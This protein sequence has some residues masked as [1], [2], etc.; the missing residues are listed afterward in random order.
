[1]LLFNEFLHTSYFRVGFSLGYVLVFIFYPLLA[2]SMTWKTSLLS[3]KL[4]SFYIRNFAPKRLVC[5]FFGQNYCIKNFINH[6]IT[7]QIID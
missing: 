5:A 3:L 2:I 6:F 7:D 1:M 4:H